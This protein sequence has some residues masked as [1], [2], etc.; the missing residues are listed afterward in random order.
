MSLRHTIK[1]LLSGPQTQASPPGGF[2]YNQ[3]PNPTP[4]Q[5]H[6]AQQQFGYHQAA[7]VNYGNSGGQ[8]VMVPNPQ[9]Y[10]YPPPPSQFPQMYAPPPHQQPQQYHCPPA[11]L[12][13]APSGPLYHQNHNAFTPQSGLSYAPASVPPPLQQSFQPPNSQIQQYGPTPS[14]TS[15]FQQPPQPH[16]LAQGQ[17]LPPKQYGPPPPVPSATHPNY[18]QPVANPLHQEQQKQQPTSNPVQQYANVPHL[19]QDQQQPPRTPLSPPPP[20]MQFEQP[21]ISQAAVQPSGPAATS[22]RPTLNFAPPPLS[23]NPKPPFSQIEEQSQ[24]QSQSRQ[25]YANPYT[26]SAPKVNPSTS[27]TDLGDA[28][29]SIPQQTSH[30]KQTHIQADALDEPQRPA[31]T[32][33]QSDP[34]AYEGATPTSYTPT[35][36]IHPSMFTQ[37]NTATSVTS[38]RVPNLLAGQPQ[39]PTKSMSAKPPPAAA[40]INS[41]PPQPTYP[42]IK[43]HKPTQSVN[44]S[45]TFSKKNADG[46]PNWNGTLLTIDGMSSETFTRFVNGLYNFAGQDEDPLGLTPDQMR[47]LLERLD[48]PDERNYPKRY[49]LAA[50]KAKPADPASFVHTSLIQYYSIFDV[51]YITEGNLMPI[52]TRDGFQQY[53]TAE[54]LI[55]PSGMHRRFLR[56]LA[57]FGNQIIDPFT[58]IPFGNVQFQREYLPPV[59]NDQYIARD[60]KQQEALQAREAHDSQQYYNIDQQTSGYHQSGSWGI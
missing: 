40:T 18:Q 58:K 3:A 50:P 17:Y 13:S 59:P 5:P 41:A 14:T 57:N 43:G 56:L 32:K 49:S 20:Y 21:F 38:G 8:P 54:V 15:I 60:K 12:N 31:S 27:G 36:I 28:S 23:N 26:A 25:Q 16:T 6:H 33:P 4:N 42:G 22:P 11:P 51:T 9:S 1:T 19:R 34:V 53:M 39:S 2:G 30:L 29:S 44:R 45:L 37:W 55:D 7:P 46:S 48:M 35:G 24:E 47:I 10:G 52:V